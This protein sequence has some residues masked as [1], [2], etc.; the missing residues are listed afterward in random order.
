[1]VLPSLPSHCRTYHTTTHTHTHT[2]THTRTHTHTHARTHTHTHAQ[3]MECVC[4]NLTVVYALVAYSDLK[5]REISDVLVSSQTQHTTNTHSTLSLSLSLSSLRLDPV[6]LQVLGQNGKWSQH[7]SWH[8]QQCSLNHS[9]PHTHH[10]LYRLVPAV[11]V[12]L[13][14]GIVASQYG[15]V[16]R[17]TECS[18]WSVSL[19]FLEL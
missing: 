17:A 8:G 14:F 11:C 6:S 2:H 9:D 15:L 13:I 16:D 3:I 12:L 19:P 5:K 18:C 10:L 4:V 7:I 1:M